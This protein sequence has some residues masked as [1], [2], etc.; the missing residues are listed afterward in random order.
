MTISLMIDSDEISP[1][2]T[3]SYFYRVHRGCYESLDE[4]QQ[5]ILDWEIVDSRAKATRENN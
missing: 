4:E 1:R 5:A 3:R 2:D